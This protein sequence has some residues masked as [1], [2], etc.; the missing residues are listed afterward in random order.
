M[1][2]YSSVRAGS[3]WPLADEPLVTVATAPLVL[4]LFE[5]FVWLLPTGWAATA[6]G[7]LWFDENKGDKR[8]SCVWY[9]TCLSKALFI[10]SSCEAE[11]S[12]AALPFCSLIV[13]I[14]FISASTSAPVVGE[15]P[16]R[17][18]IAINNGFYFQM[19]FSKHSIH[20]INI[21]IRDSDRS[22]L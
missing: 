11:S 10:R 1:N 9:S 8:S 4:L 14:F 7:E 22:H 2:L 15:L 13:C 17:V 6:W 3:T 20:C 5:L 12:S 21:A 18:N 16:N 19:N